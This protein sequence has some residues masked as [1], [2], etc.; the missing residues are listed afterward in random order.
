LWAKKD[1]NM[2]IRRFFASLLVLLVCLLAVSQPG[3]AQTNNGRILGTVQD[4]SGAVV[5]GAHLT[6]VNVKTQQKTEAT[7]GSQGE[8]VLTALPPGTYKL[9]V[10]AAGFR[11][12]E[13]QSIEVNVGAEVAQLIKLEVGTTSETVVVEASTVTVQTTESQV[14]R[15][16][17]LRDIDTLPQL[18]RTPITL[19]VFQTGVQINPSDASYS[20]VNGGRMGSNNSRLDGIDVNDSVVPRLGLSMTA[21]NTDSIGE[22]RIVLGAGKAEY[23]RSA[24]GQVELITRSGTNSFH[25][26]GFWYLRR[27]DLN[28]NDFFSNQSGTLR[29]LFS[30]NITGGS[31][32]G[33]IRKDKTFFFGNFQR[34][35]TQQET[36]RNR[37]VYTPTAKQGLFRWTTAG[38][39]Q[40]FNFAANGPTA[41]PRGKGVDPAVAKIN[42]Q[43]PD[44][45][46]TDLGDGLNT[47]GFRFNTPSNSLEDQTTI[48]VDHN[49]TNNNR[50]FVRYSFQRNSS[51]DTLNSAERTYPGQI[52]G[53]QGGHRWGFSIGDDWTLR[54]N[55]INEFRVGY[56]KST[57]AFERPNR[58][59]GPDYITN[60]VYDVQYS[61][62]PQGRWS[63]VTDITENLT[64]L[65]GKHVLKMGT[66][67]RHTLQY[68]YD[69]AGVYPNLTPAV[70]NGNIVAA[71][72]GPQGLTATQR[73]TFERLYNDILGR[74]DRVTMTFYSDLQKFQPAGA[75]RVRNYNLNEG[76]IFFQDDWK[77]TRKLTL[78]VGLRYEL[79]LVPKESGTLQGVIDKANIVN[80]WTP[81]TDLTLVRGSNWFTTDKNNFAPRI[82]FAYDLTGNGRTALRGSYGIYY[83]RFMGAVTSTVDGSTPGFSQAVPV[84]P[85]SNNND[86]RFSENY[87]LP[88]TPAAP[89]LTLPT[90]RS[91]ALRM[92]SPN[93]RTGYV[94]NFS[95]NVQHEVFR[96]TVVD[97]GFVG[98]RGVKLFYFRDVNQPHTPADF[99]SSFKEMQA[100]AANSSAAVPAGNVF[101]RMFGTAASAL[102][103]IGATSF[104]QGLVGTVINTLDTNSTNYA[105][106]TSAGLP[107]TYFRPYPQFTTVGLGT[108]DGHSQYNSLQVGVRRNTGALRMS[109]NY[110]WSHSMDN[111]AGYSATSSAA[112][113]NGYTQPIDNFNLGLMRA[114]SDFDHRHAF[115][116]SISY[117]LPFGKGKKFGRDMGRVMNAFLGGWDL[118]ALTIWQSGGPYTV[119][120]SRATGPQSGVN[121]WANYTGSKGIGAVDR[122]GD[123]VYFLPAGTI[124]KFGYPNAFEV[125]TYGRNLLTGP[126]F[127]DTDMS[128]VK[129]FRITD[130]HAATFRAEAYNLFNNPNFGGM[131]AGLTAP[132]TFG[133]FSSTIGATGTNARVMQL[134]LRYDF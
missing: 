132:A 65:K 78:N 58:P 27:T 82:G 124:D 94:Q 108:N 16:V 111:V 52:D 122:R 31:F 100:Y 73:T 83:D 19:A 76:G 121:T 26:N 13:I 18:A 99:I 63:P 72:I 85:N 14:S 96:N 33:R 41:D 37:T 128:M 17:N 97:V 81:A 46:N 5:P 66:N 118:G 47:A 35:R 101:V 29:P 119:F 42:A 22:F 9:T 93:L 39:T 69:Q 103:T 44:P 134:S 36:V 51:I 129:R 77:I 133:K 50:A 95:L 34:R 23:G 32:G 127:F 55:L 38:V 88:Q 74:I 87:P 130:R 68:G 11:K 61:G 70:A 3:T 4:P 57:V 125:G 54:P 7:S 6:A 62:F 30:Q 89:V 15:S 112:E 102:S 115:N 75:P 123:G 20:R 86:M 98:N 25:G 107:L 64:W 24:G 84:Y 40:S 43:M 105:R 120:S 45:N 21:N 116:S 113:G 8:F 60:L 71:A 12:A 106:M 117:S 67:I 79:F 56:Q 114:T 131:S 48:K 80:G 110:T 1:L 53:T 104:T 59:Q 92:M 10:E 2:S 28:A 91:T 126:R 90:T 49:V 109:L